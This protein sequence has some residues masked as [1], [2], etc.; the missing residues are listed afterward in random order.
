M[1]GTSPDA[2]RFETVSLRFPGALLPAIDRCSLSFKTGELTVILGPSGCGKTTLM[3]MV[4]RLVE[5]TSGCIYLHDIDIRSLP[6]TQLRQRIGYAIQQTGLFPHMTVAQNVAVVPQLLGWS[7][8]RVAAR[9]DELLEL[10]ELPAWEFRDRWPAQLSGGQQ[11][12]VGV[13]RALAG[14]PEV[15]LMDEPFGA[16]D[17]I[18]R[19]SL[20]DELLRLQQRLRKTILFVSHDVD[21][22]LR[23]ADRLLILEKGQVVQFDPP[24]RVLTRPANAFVRDLMGADDIGRQLGLIPAQAVMAQTVMQGSD[25]DATAPTIEGR[26]SLRQALSLLLRTGTEQLTVTAGDRAIGVLKLEHIRAAAKTASQE[27]A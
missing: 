21:E 20:Q 11:Q 24:L 22:A 3:K 16:L 14:D 12:R 6:A 18:T 4:N 15:L 1:A 9:V 23:L 13:A 25:R 8:S 10:V 7:R 27:R 19:V 5:P 2:I 26:E 17:A